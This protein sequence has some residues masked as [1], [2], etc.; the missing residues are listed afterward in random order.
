[1]PYLRIRA[2]SF[3]PML[4]AFVGFSTFRGTMDVT[5]SVKIALFANIVT[6][7]LDPILIHVMGLGVRGSAFA[8]L[9]GDLVNAAI[10]L[11]LLTDKNLIHVKKLLRLPSWAR[12]APLLKGGIALQIRSL[13]LNLTQLM[14]TRTI[15]S[16]D[17][18]GVAPA[19]HALAMQTFMM[20]G[21]FLGA[22]GMSTQTMIPNAMAKEK[23]PEHASFEQSTSYVDL[24]VRRL[25]RWG[26]GLGVTV[27]L[28]QMALIPIILNSS[29]LVEVRQAARIPALL[30]MSFQ[31]ISGFVNVG[32]G[33]M[34]GMGDFTHLAVNIVVGA[35]AYIGALRLFS[36]TF[37]L[38]G[39]WMG[40]AVFAMVRAAG[41]VFHSLSKKRLEPLSGYLQE[42]EAE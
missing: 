18:T 41:V 1:M 21:I 11:K 8:A 37:G 15:Q 17:G 3:L 13:A 39:V 28:I 4:V 12:V 32:E 16:I 35:F 27:G 42:S 40:N 25:F 14:S 36:P 9:A 33:V 10:N 38:T 7:V 22:L 29:P 34:M 30:S 20:G 5:T 26:I 24:L 31:W 23:Y 6:L 2:F 19:A